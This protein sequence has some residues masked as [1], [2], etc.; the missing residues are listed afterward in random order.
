MGRHLTTL[1]DT[2]DLAILSFISLSDSGSDLTSFEP[3]SLFGVCFSL[4]AVD[5]AQGP[6]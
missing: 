6:A 3:G 5:G 4:D 2:R 1:D